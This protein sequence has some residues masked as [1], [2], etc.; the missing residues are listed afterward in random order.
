MLKLIV[1]EVLIYNYINDFDKI[2][3]DIDECNDVDPDTSAV[4]HQC[5]TGS[6]MCGLVI[7]SF[8]RLYY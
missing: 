1:I 6:G 7:V 3:L 2:C 5:D 8:T 4:Y